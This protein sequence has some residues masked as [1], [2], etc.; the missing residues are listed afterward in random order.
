MTLQIGFQ[1]S[2]R[3]VA[4]FRNCE[5][6]HASLK[7][8]AHSMQSCYNNIEEENFMN[9]SLPK[10]RNEEGEELKKEGAQ[11]IPLKISVKLST[12]THFKIVF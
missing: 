3:V 5:T 9:A 7:G 10:T 12:F 4:A 1:L 2:S 11:R 8:F 6:V